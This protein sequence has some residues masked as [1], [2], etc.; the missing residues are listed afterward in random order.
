MS[1]PIFGSEE[2]K[3]TTSSISAHIHSRYLLIRPSFSVKK[4]NTF[5]EII[6]F[7]GVRPSHGPLCRP[8]KDQCAIT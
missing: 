2:S 5:A 8:V 7:V 4:L 6:S 1:Q 3:M